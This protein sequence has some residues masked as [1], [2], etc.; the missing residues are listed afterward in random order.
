M[1]CRINR[2]LIFR[3]VVKVFF[4]YLWSLSTFY[5]QV[6]NKIL[7]NSKMVVAEV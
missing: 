6:I 2:Q 7:L 3:V 5:P 4:C 1:H